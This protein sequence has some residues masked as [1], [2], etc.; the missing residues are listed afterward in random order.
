MDFSELLQSMRDALSNAWTRVGFIMRTHVLATAFIVLLFAGGLVVWARSGFTVNVSRFFAATPTPS[1]TPHAPWLYCDYTTLAGACVQSPPNGNGVSEDYDAPDCTAGGGACALGNCRKWEGSGETLASWH[2]TSPPPN[3]PAC[4]PITK[5][6]SGNFSGY[7]DAPKNPAPVDFPN[8]LVIDNRDSHDPNWGTMTE[9][10]VPDVNRGTPVPKLFYKRFVINNCPWEVHL[11]FQVDGGP[12]AS[13]SLG[14]GTRGGLSDEEVS[15]GFKY[16]NL[17]EGFDFPSCWNSGATSRPA[18]CGREITI[19]YDLNTYT[20][21]SLGVTLS[22]WHRVSNNE[23]GGRNATTDTRGMGFVSSL[24]YGK[25]CTGSPLERQ[26]GI[27][28]KSPTPT[29]VGGGTHAPSVLAVQCG[30]TQNVLTWTLPAGHDSN[31]LLRSADGGGNTFLPISNNTQATFT[32]TNVQAGHR[33]TYTH[34]AWTDKTSNSVSCPTATISPTGTISASVSP[35]ASPQSS[36]AVTSGVSPT[37]TLYYFASPTPY[38]YSYTP[39]TGQ[40]GGTGG[41]TTASGVQTGPGDATLLALIISALVSLL[42]VSYTHSPLAR[43]HEAEDISR[44]Q[45]PMDFRT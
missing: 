14:A 21:G 37:P 42:Y 5:V 13:F 6:D 20:C 43:K 33:Y 15:R 45:G 4:E 16:T 10:I 36:P 27:P 41:A 17:P 1:P 19:E 12:K 3:I 44:D 38:L 2:P 34:K 11:V 39:P 32:D 30:A 35:G 24:N 7:T 9:H 23:L 22:W 31:G 29:P 28:L 8:C 18:S 26:P 25:D 40:A